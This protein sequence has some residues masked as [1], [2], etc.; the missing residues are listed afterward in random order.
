MK[1]IKLTTERHKMQKIKSDILCKAEL[2]EHESLNPGNNSERRTE[3]RK[4]MI[5]LYSQAG[6]L[7][8]NIAAILE[9]EAKCDKMHINLISAISCYLKAEDYDNAA[10]LLYRYYPKDGPK[11][12]IAI[13]KELWAGLDEVYL[14]Q[15]LKQGL[16]DEPIPLRAY[17]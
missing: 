16:T 11:Y 5:F 2:A 13:I 17:I 12:S 8:V 3:I 7:E 14:K 4:D 1:K 9:R 10:K 15:D 6:D